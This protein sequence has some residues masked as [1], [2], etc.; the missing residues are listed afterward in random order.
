MKD[1]IITI[2]P[3]VP[4][5]WALLLLRIREIPVSTLGPVTGYKD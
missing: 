2:F 4:V 1:M 5:E 3:N